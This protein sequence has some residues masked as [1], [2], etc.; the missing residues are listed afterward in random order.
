MSFVRVKDYCIRN[1]S[2]LI[3]S[4]GRNTMSYLSSTIT[5]Q[6]IET[7]LDVVIFHIYLLIFSFLQD[8]L[9]LNYNLFQRWW[10][11][12]SVFGHF[13]LDK[14]KNMQLFIKRLFIF[15]IHSKRWKNLMNFRIEF[16]SKCLI[17]QEKFDELFCYI[18][19]KK[20]SLPQPKYS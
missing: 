13:N 8:F 4:L 11:W 6:N 2:N 3:E 7:P 19:A 17:N 18:N 15:T 5:E 1:I 12:A 9:C 14:D 10:L 20:L 16:I